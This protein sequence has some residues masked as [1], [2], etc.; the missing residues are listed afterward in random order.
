MRLLA[1]PMELST[2]SSSPDDFPLMSYSPVTGCRYYYDSY[3]GG[4]DRKVS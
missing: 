2:G 3:F 1:V 4:E